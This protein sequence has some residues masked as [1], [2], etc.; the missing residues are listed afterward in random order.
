MQTIWVDRLGFDFPDGWTVGKYDDWSFYRHR[1]SKI[2]TALKA[3]DLLAVSPSGTAWLIEVK[4][5]RVYQR[6]KP[7]NLA[8]E[9][10]Q[11]VLDTLAAI[12]PAKINGNVEGETLVATQVAQAHVLRVVLH[13]EQPAKHS[14]LF[15][16]AID[17]ADVQMQLR[18]QLKPVD[19]HP[20]VVDT[21]NLQGVPW[22]AS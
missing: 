21:A 15:P 10:R 3:L 14:K 7:T 16:R 4:D 2:P 9:V 11:K 5:Y 13:L 19:P 6:S 8:D 22:T 12:L 17:P 1:F 20:R 18:R